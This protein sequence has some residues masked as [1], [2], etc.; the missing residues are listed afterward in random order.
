ME[1]CTMQEEWKENKTSKH[2]FIP[3]QREEKEQRKSCLL[4]LS[5]YVFFF[6]YQNLS[7]TFQFFTY[8]TKT[9]GD[10]CYLNGSYLVCP[11][12]SEIVFS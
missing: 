10:I 3:K 12:Y 2:L 4:S 1:F 9:Y 5:L 6:N 7:A 8:Q 11:V